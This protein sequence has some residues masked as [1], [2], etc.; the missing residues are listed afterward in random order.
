MSEELKSCPMCG[1]HAAITAM[2]DYHLAMCCVCCVNYE[3]PTAKDCAD[4]WNRRTP[5]ESTPAS[6]GRVPVVESANLVTIRSRLKG[7]A[8]AGAPITLS[9]LAACALYYAMDTGKPMASDDPAPVAARELDVEAERREFE[10]L[11]VPERSRETEIDSDGDTVYVEDWMQG[12]FIGYQLGRAARSAAQSTAPVDTLNTSSERVQNAQGNRHVEGTCQGDSEPVAWA[13]SLDLAFKPM[14]KPDVD[15]GADCSW[16][17]DYEP[18]PLYRHPAPAQKNRRAESAQVSTE[19][20]GD[21]WQVVPK[22]MTMD[23]HVAFAEVW[24][25]KVRPIDDHDMQ[26]AYAAMLEAA[27]SPNNSPVGAEKEPK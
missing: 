2:E 19:Q 27:P 13:C 4:A 8:Q 22:E 11:I 5:A 24:F 23:M 25:S 14:E 6:T 16:H 15:W 7:A 18:F 20:A 1:G 17:P 9:G 26:D 21:A 12:A 3:G 10:A